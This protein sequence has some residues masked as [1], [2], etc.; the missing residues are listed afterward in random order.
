MAITGTRAGRSP[1]SRGTRRR[2]SSRCTHTVTATTRASATRTSWS[3]AWAT[4]RWIL[5]SSR[6]TS[7]NTRGCPPGGGHGSCPSTCSVARSTS[8]ATTRAFRSGSAAAWSR[9]SFLPPRARS[10]STGCPSPTTGSGRPTRRSRAGSSTASAT[11]RSRR[12]PTSPACTTVR[13]S[14]PTGHAS[15]ATWSSTAPG[16]RSPSRSSTRTSSPLPTTTSSCSA[17]SSTPASRRVLRRSAAA[18]GR[19]HA[20]GGGAGHVDRGPPQRHLRAAGAGSG[21]CRTSV[22]TT[23]RWPSAT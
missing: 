21:A 9:R 11:G 18:A 2:A 20:A 10:R 17:G 23:R 1:R 16:T 8:F 14:S 6:P 15:R 12:S 7:R 5:R 19:R 13:S 22:T 3:W 4:A